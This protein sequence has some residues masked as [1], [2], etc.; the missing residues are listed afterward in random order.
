MRRTILL[1]ALIIALF[2]LL[3]T[4]AADGVTLKP[5]WTIKQP[6]NNAAIQI[7]QTFAVDRLTAYTT[8]TRIDR[9]NFSITSTT[10]DDIT[11]NLSWYNKTAASGRYVANFSADTADG[12]NVNFSL[13][14]PA[15]QDYTVYRDGSAIKQVDSLSG[16]LWFNHSTWSSHSFSVKVTGSSCIQNEKGFGTTYQ[17]G[18]VRYG[19][20]IDQNYTATEQVQVENTDS[21]ATN[22]DLAQELEPVTKCSAENDTVQ[23]IPADSV[24]N[25]TFH[26]DCRPGVE[27]SYQ[28]ITTTTQTD[29]TKWFCRTHAI[30]GYQHYRFEG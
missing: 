14:L 19:Q 20:G 16:V 15:S 23:S 5:T 28:A 26:K 29:Y 25:L 2:V 13:E 8:A 22:A 7:N 10:G 1:A 24:V 4:A 9:S 18:T 12:N 21:S 3:P 30:Y 27:V 17:S 6:G 11:V